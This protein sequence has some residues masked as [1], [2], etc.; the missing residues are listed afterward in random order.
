MEDS[1][2]RRATVAH[3]LALAG[4]LLRID[5]AFRRANIPFLAWKGPVLAH[6]LYGEFTQRRFHDLDVLLN[7][8]DLP[9]ARAVLHGLGYHAALALT[10]AQQ[11]SFLRHHHEQVLTGSAG[12]IVE[13]HWQVVQ[14]Q[15]AV[16]YP[17]EQL[18]Q[19]A[20]RV[21]FQGRELLHPGPDDTVVLAALHAA[22]HLWVQRDLLRDLGAAA[23]LV[24][25]WTRVW[26][27]AQSAHVQ[28]Y[29][30]CGLLLAAQL[31]HARLSSAVESRVRADRS[32]LR[33]ADAC[34]RQHTRATV[35]ADW[36][37]GYAGRERK[38]DRARMFAR[39]LFTPTFND[40]SDRQIPDRW[41]FL[42][43][44][45]S[46]ASAAQR[47]RQR[48][49]DH[50]NRF[51]NSQQVLCQAQLEHGHVPAEPR[52]RLEVCAQPR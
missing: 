28:R 8:A 44:F 48:S 18:F 50:L 35:C 26:A 36:W 39:T 37:W 32:A 43:Y 10:P 40:W 2:L 27:I 19:R 42:Y 11:R 46:G 38:R 25:D 33:L 20:Q 45:A 24:R 7:S 47:V 22:K 16:E 34:A 51:L 1:D 13:L 30:A 15:F 5:A 17:V 52:A 23:T 29:L 49:A 12:I 3:N 4:E 41:H 6:L 9:R 14:R 21:A 31:S